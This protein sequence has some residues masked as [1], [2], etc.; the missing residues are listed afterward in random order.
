MSFHH[1]AVRWRLVALDV[2]YPERVGLRP[3]EG[4][5]DEI[6]RGRALVRAPRPVAVGQSLQ[7]SSAHQHRDSVVADRDP[8]TEP[9]LGMDPQGAVGPAGVQMDLSDLVRQPGVA[10]RSSGGCSVKSEETGDL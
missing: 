7:T 1:R 9:E 2:G 6:G 4:P 10:D 8:L 3:R 5:V